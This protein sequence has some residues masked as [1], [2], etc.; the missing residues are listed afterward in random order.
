MPL[1]KDI[2]RKTVPEGPIKNVMRYFYHKINADGF[3]IKY[4]I[5]KKSFR[6]K[7]REGNL[8]GK[9]IEL[10]YCSLKLL[11][12]VQKAFSEYLSFG[13]ISKD[14]IIVDSGAYPGDFTIV[15]AQMAD[16]VIAIEPD[17]YNRDYLKKVVNLNGISG[18]V[19]IVG[20]GLSDKNGNAYLLPELKSSKICNPKDYNPD[21]LVQ[22]K[23]IT[24]DSLLE[25]RNLLG[26]SNNL[27]VKM[28]IE[29]EEVNAIKGAT[30][31][32]EHGAKFVIAAYHLYDGQQTII[33]L[34][35][36]FKE[37]GYSVL[38]VNPQH[39]TLIAS[40]TY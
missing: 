12:G 6:L 28:D 23:T 22:I 9:S 20:Y 39:L 33:P 16:R 24:L 8:K 2:L 1:I 37:K 14:T 11:L 21:L 31:T 27:F 18:K 4:S 19:E 5:I 32:I 13:K 30:K 3:D 17:P 26:N 40:P 10:P 35:K 15:A 25:E 38:R 36:M 29:G 7:F 34:E